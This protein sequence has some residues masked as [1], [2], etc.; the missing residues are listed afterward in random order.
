MK[1]VAHG[2][3]H[4]GFLT[5]GVVMDM[6]KRNAGR[7]DE[8]IYHREGWGLSH[9]EMAARMARI[10]DELPCWANW[11]ADRKTSIEELHAAFTM[12][13]SASV[14]RS[15]DP[16]RVP[17][18]A[19]SSMSREDQEIYE[20]FIEWLREV[21]RAKRKRYIAMVQGVIVSND[22]CPDE[23]L[24]AD[25]VGYHVVIRAREMQRYVAQRQ[26]K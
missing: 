14:V 16:N 7:A 15:F 11:G 22:R 12:R 17:H 25:M 13:C 9:E 26:R 8:D 1:R 10:A 3:Y 2:K 4:S 18:Q 20:R 23:R 6:G 24:F 21:H 5:Q 19:S